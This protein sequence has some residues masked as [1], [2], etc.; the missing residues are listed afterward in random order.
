MDLSEYEKEIKSMNTE[1]EDAFRMM[2]MS[3]EGKSEKFDELERYE[4]KKNELKDKI[5]E[6]KNSSTN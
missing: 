2:K 3:R 6:L 5:D 4:L 1:I